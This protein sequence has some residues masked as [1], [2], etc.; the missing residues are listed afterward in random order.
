MNLDEKK[1]D[2]ELLTGNKK[3]GKTAKKKAKATEVPVFKEPKTVKKAKK[4]AEK[5]PAKSAKK[6]TKTTASKSRKK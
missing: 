4:V 5:K 3:T 1:I 6:R 2:F